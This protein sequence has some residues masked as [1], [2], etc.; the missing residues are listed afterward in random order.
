MGV[1]R[2]IENIVNGIMEDL[3]NRRGLGF[4]NIDDDVIEEIKDSWKN[5]IKSEFE[6]VDELEDEDVLK[7][8]I[9]DY[10]K[11]GGNM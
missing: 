4:D 8:V 6:K 7:Q 11:I 5:I 9:L 3:D 1:D 2:M 10:F